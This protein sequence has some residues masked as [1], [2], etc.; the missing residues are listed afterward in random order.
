MIFVTLGTQKQQF[1]RILE[2]IE[3]S[4]VLNNEEIIVQAGHTKYESNKMKISTFYSMDE[5]KDYMKKAD[6]V[7]THGGVGSIIDALN[8]RKKVLAVPRLS[9]YKE[10][11]NDHQLEI[12]EKLSSEGYI[13]Q[14]LEGESIDEKIEKLKDNNYKE[15]I[16]ET[17]YLEIIE[18]TIDGFLK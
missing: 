14:L 9:K 5:M 15:Y 17:K 3:K 1:T 13:E 2:E 6:I 10:H 18:K 11:I 12:C 4:K 16:P 7:I 8:L